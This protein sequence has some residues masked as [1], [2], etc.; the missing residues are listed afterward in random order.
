[1]R[2]RNQL[3]RVGDWTDVNGQS[4]VDGCGHWGVHDFFAGPLRRCRSA[5]EAVELRKLRQHV[6]AASRLVA[7]LDKL[8]LMALCDCENR[9]F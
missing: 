7:S 8:D 6:V 5:S 9:G 1:M 3:N 2:L 4:L